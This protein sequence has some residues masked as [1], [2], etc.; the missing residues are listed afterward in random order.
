MTKSRAEQVA[1]MNN[2]KRGKAA[3]L[4]DS[5]C[6][7]KQFPSPLGNPGMKLRWGCCF[8]YI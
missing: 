4:E 1:I 7:L 8:L 3:P 5:H 2:L 6:F